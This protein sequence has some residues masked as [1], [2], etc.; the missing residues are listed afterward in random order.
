MKIG[1]SHVFVLVLALII[2]YAAFVSGSGGYCSARE[3]FSGRHDE[4]D[5]A[6]IAK[7]I[8]RAD[9]GNSFAENRLRYPTMEYI[10]RVCEK[11]VE[12]LGERE[13][14]YFERYSKDRC[15]AWSFKTPKS[16][17][18]EAN[19]TSGDTNAT[20]DEGNLT[21]EGANTIRNEAGAIKRDVN[22]TGE[23]NAGQ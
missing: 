21:R 17:G 13:R 16:K 5:D 3:F 15:S 12:S 1:K 8:K 19:T 11:G 22:S 10:K 2:I 6:C 9:D 4:E 7:L 18:G 14:F 23:S 20:D